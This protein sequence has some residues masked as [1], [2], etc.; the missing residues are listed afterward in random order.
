MVGL[1][2]A[3]P[4]TLTTFQEIPDIGPSWTFVATYGAARCIG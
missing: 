4:K 2:E 1:G 3:A